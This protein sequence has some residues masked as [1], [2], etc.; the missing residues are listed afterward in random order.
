MSKRETVVLELDPEA[1]TAAKAKGL[2]LSA[3]LLEA[4]H[5]RIPELHAEQRA[6]SGRRWRE[7]NRET[8]VSINRLAEDDARSF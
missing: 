7:Q 3:V 2:D 4:L 8:I 1:I 6:E 5:R